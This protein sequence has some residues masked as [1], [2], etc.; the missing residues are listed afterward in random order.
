MEL[1]KKIQQ[2]GFSR[3]EAE[4]YIALL[5]KKEFTASEL[6]KI[7]TVTR[8]KIYEMLQNMVRKGICNENNKNGQKF[9]RAVKPKIILQDV[10]SN[11][12]LEIEQQ[13]KAAIEQQKKNDL[14]LQKKTAIEQNKIMALEKKIINTIEQKKMTAMSLEKE[15]S[16]LHENN[17]NNFESLDYIEV[18]TDKGQIK[19]KW[20][21]IQQNT[22][23]ELLAF[24]KPPYV[25]SLEDNIEKEQEAMKN[26]IVVK[27]IYE[28]KHLTSAKEKKNFIE[29]IESYQRLG[30][31]AK[32]ID[33][34]PMKL[35]ISDETI[36]MLSLTDRISMQPSITTIVIDHPSYAAASKKIFESY[37]A[38]AISI[39]D[40]IS[41]LNK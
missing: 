2:I 23:K 10:I 38:S 3:R 37:W 22:K 8:T 24:T 4:I 41:D 21:T 40:F 12:D 30:E 11:Y 7:T 5:Q 20:L 1:I 26:K 9:Y 25:V 16:S 15:L 35:A 32:I 13:K 14:A 39:E 34:L 29:I 28:C 6:A 19:E 33:E 36:T 31:E 17:L 18:L 27:G